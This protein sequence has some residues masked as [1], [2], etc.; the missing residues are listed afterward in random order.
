MT[1]MQLTR[2]RIEQLRQF[3]QPYELKDFEPGWTISPWVTGTA[4]K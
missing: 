3:R 1:R 4:P 2:L